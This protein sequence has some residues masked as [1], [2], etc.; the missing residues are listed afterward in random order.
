MHK[1]N[2]RNNVNTFYSKHF[3]HFRKKLCHTKYINKQRDNIPVDERFED[4]IAMPI[5]A[6]GKMT[7]EERLKIEDK[8][9]LCLRYLLGDILFNNKNKKQYF[10]FLNI[11]FIIK[12]AL[13]VVRPS[14][15]WISI[16]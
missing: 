4:F 7:I 16:K 13:S 5:I 3:D 1:A 10:L 15:G 12:R 8:M 6:L 11:Y 14:S 2:I 9:I